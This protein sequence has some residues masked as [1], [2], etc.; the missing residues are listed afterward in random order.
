[1][2]GNTGVGGMEKHVVGVCRD[3]RDAGL[4]ITAC[5][6]EGGW[7]A[8][9][10]ANEVEVLTLP[11]KRHFDISSRGG[12]RRVLDQ[13]KP[14]IVHAH[15]PV[16]AKIAC[17][18][19]KP[20]YKLVVT[21]HGFSQWGD[22]LGEADAVIAVSGST[23]ERIA[24]FARNAGRVVVIYNGIDCQSVWNGRDAR[25]TFREEFAL[26]DRPVIMSVGRLVPGKGNHV[27]I[28]ATPTI[29]ARHPNALIAIVGGRSRMY[30][31][32]LHRL[33]RKLDV[34]DSVLFLG[35]RNDIPRLLAGATILAQPS[36]K[37]AHPL[38]VI[39]AMSAGVPVVGT[40]SGGMT[41][42]IV[43]GQT[44]LLVD[45]DNHIQ[46]A[47]AIL[48]L[49]DSADLRRSIGEAGRQHAVSSLSRERMNAEIIAL[50]E[51]LLGSEQTAHYAQVE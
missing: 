45:P 27:L 29:L 42:M 10:L 32:Y 35:Q 37:D 6:K 7:A 41:E 13:V 8:G 18:V 20:P 31:S 34:Q 33:C 9:T 19:V 28:N 17:S 4:H 48:K 3:L 15:G 30:E 36:L 12:L 21:V 47:D 5:C 25:P 38:S 22:W 1:M 50:Y 39:E 43:D 26:A 23:K 49:L 16:A 44:G 46:L 14:D 24:N 51:Q 40:R 2:C 11:M